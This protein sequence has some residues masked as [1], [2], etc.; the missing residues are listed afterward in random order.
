VIIY[1]FYLIGAK[2][3]KLMEAWAAYC[4]GVAVGGAT[5]DVTTAVVNPEKM[6]I[7]AE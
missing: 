6:P 4:E 5:D 2:R 1:N 3:R 7:A